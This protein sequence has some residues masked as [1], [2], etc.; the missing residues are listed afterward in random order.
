[1]TNWKSQTG[2]GKYALQFESTDYALYK[3]V[4]KA[5]QKAVDEANKNRDKWRKNNPELMR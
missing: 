3:L 2:E 5:A 4:E 1:M